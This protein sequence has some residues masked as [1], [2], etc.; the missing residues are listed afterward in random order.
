MK[1]EPTEEARK[2]GSKDA[3]SL[4]LDF[5][6][7]ARNCL[8]T[9]D[10]GDP[11]RCACSLA[12]QAKEKGEW[13]AG[14]RE[15]SVTLPPGNFYTSQVLWR[16]VDP[17]LPGKAASVP[18]DLQRK[19]RSCSSTERELNIRGADSLCGAE[20]SWKSIYSEAER[21]E[22]E[23]AAVPPP[24]PCRTF[25][26]LAEKGAS[27]CSTA[28]ATREAPLQEQHG[29]DSVSSSN[30]PEKRIASR[31]IRGR[32]QRYMIHLSCLKHVSLNQFLDGFK[33]LVFHNTLVEVLVLMMR[34]LMGRGY[35]WMKVSLFQHSVCTAFAAD[36]LAKKAKSSKQMLVP[37]LKT[38]LSDNMLVPGR[39]LPASCPE[40]VLSCSSWITE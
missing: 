8:Q 34:L 30:N 16:R 29:G 33:Q 9:D 5:R 24:K 18:L 20:R 10:C 32:T 35:F 11:K 38:E 14:F 22:E 19:R 25:R 21:Q 2:T 4:G 27:S 26:Y 17:L 7:D 1:P 12:S 23:S 15:P 37:H 13:Q 6:E 28:S 3:K 39:V 36:N 40:L 31:R